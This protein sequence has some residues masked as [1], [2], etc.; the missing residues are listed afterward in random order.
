MFK[1]FFRRLV[2][3]SFVLASINFVTGLAVKVFYKDSDKTAKHQYESPI[4]HEFVSIEAH[5]ISGP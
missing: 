5:A 4:I 1:R 3:V 2:T